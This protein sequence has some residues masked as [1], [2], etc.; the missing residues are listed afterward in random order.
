VK[1]FGAMCVLFSVCMQ[2]SVQYAVSLLFVLSLLLFVMFKLLALCFYYS[3]Y[4]SC[5]VCFVFHFCVLSVCIVSCI[6][7]P[8]VFSGQE[9][10]LYAR[11]IF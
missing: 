9:H 6:V 11:I 8:H 7:S 5:F 10:I 3:F 2:V 4:V 1:I